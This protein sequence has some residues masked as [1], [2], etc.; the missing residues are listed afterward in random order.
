MTAPDLTALEAKAAKAQASYEAAL[1]TAQAAREAEQARRDARARQLDEQIVSTYDDEQMF[2]GIR[3]A[4]QE[5]TRALAES[6]IG[7][8]WIA[9]QLAELR[10][11]H[12]SSDYNMA[13]SRLGRFERVP[14]R[15]AGTAVAE[16]LAQI[17][18][19]IAADA[20]AAELDA[21]DE[22]RQAHIVGTDK[23]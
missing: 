1:A 5:L 8:A 13:A 12:A 21:R 20:L 10:H 9:V 17:V 22:A 2:R 18:D 4:R 16:H 19:T 3:E 14:S 11:A 6:D 7:K 15:P 23:G